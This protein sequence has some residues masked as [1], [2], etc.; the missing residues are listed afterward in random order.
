MKKILFTFIFLLTAISA[1]AFYVKVDGIY[2]DLVT[3]G[4]VAFVAS[5]KENTSS[6]V[7]IPSTVEYDGVSYTVTTIKRGAFNACKNITKITLSNSITEIDIDAFR[8]CSALE[9]IK[10]PDYL[11]KIGEHAF[12]W[13]E[14]LTSL[15]L[16]A[17]LKEV[18][19]NAFS[20]CLRLTTVYDLLL[21][22]LK[23]LSPRWEN[24]SFAIVIT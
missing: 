21:L 2:Y 6:E 18:G 22:L 8:D 11:E 12:C 17:S 7:T 1:S 13:C 16:P 14:N 9:Q 20:Y 24:T 15:S 23:E 19:G 5:G 3:K 4:Q 10:L